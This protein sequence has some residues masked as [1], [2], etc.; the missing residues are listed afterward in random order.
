MKKKLTYLVVAALSVSMLAGCG[1]SSGEKK[2]SKVDVELTDV[3]ENAADAVTEIESVEIGV[4]ANADISGSAEGQNI[5]IKG[6]AELNGKAVLKDEPAVEGSGKVTYSLKGAG[7]DMS[8]DYKAQVYGE[9]EDDQL[10]IYVKLNDDDW[11]TDK[12]DVSGLD[13]A[14]SQ[15]EEALNQ[16]K[17][18]LG[19]ISSEDLKDVEEYVKLENKTSFVNKKECYVLSAKINKDQLLKMYEEGEDMLGGGMDQYK[20]VIEALDSF[21]ASYA[22][23]FAKDNCMPVKFEFDVTGKG[24]VEG[25]DVNIKKLGFE[26]NLGVNDVKVAPVPD[27]VKESAEETDLGLGGGY[28]DDDDYSWDDDDY[29]WDDEESDDDSEKE[30]ED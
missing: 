3:L 14:V 17:E 5:S 7:Q 28:D 4:K 23:Y 11:K 24:S 22:L 25:V 10:S 9:T 26:I 1:S 12:M 15:L 20:E 6:N 30:D 16:V 8:G 18:G 29:N 2:G 27:N 21:N 19:S 13:D